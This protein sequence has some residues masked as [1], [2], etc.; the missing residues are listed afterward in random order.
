MIPHFLQKPGWHI[1]GD[2]FT[3]HVWPCRDLIQHEWSDD[4][5]C[6]PTQKPIEREDGSIGWIVQ[7]AS[8]DGREK[9]ETDRVAEL[10][11][12][13]AGAITAVVGVLSWFI[14]RRSR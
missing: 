4:C 14:G 5:V 12:P 7:H 9:R 8:L 2:E 1:G 3:Q 10:G 13:L 6:G 11:L